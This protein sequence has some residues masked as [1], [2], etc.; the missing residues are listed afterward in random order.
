MLACN[1]YINISPEDHLIGKD[2]CGKEVRTLKESLPAVE[3]G[4][5]G[6]YA[7]TSSWLNVP[8]FLKCW[9]KVIERSSG[10]ATCG[11]RTSR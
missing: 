4:V 10:A 8:V 6:V 3:K 5:Y 9:G 11:S 7:E 1:D 2:E